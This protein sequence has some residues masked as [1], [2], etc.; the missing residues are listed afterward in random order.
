[1]AR[2]KISSSL[3]NFKILNFFKIWALRVSLRFEIA[4]IAI[5]RVL[6]ASAMPTGVQDR[7]H[8][9][10]SRRRRRSSDKENDSRMLAR[11]HQKSLQSFPSALKPLKNSQAK[12]TGFKAR[13][14]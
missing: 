6:V 13:E 14:G 12:S 10:K 5:L 11:G 4:V 2:L 3:E 9:S 1:M 7:S 8:G